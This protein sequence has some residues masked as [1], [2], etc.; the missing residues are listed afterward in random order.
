MATSQ[1]G[2]AA[3]SEQEE[4]HR[5]LLSQPQERGGA[6]DG[7][8]QRRSR[9]HLI[10]AEN[11]GQL[12]AP[13]AG[14]SSARRGAVVRAADAARD[15]AV[16]A[17]CERRT[18]NG[19]R[20]VTYVCGLYRQQNSQNPYLA[21]PELTCSCAQ[22]RRAQ[23]LELTSLLRLRAGLRLGVARL[24]LTSSMRERPRMCGA[25]SAK[26]WPQLQ[27]S[28]AHNV[29][30]ARVMLR[31]HLRLDATDGLTCCLL[32]LLGLHEGEQGGE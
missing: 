3:Q 6:D 24:L 27:S 30:Q 5:C 8:P 9:A 13:A 31:M 10:I 18:E 12:V 17:H 20:L 25:A 1:P 26:T 2:T 14:A 21:C 32:V 4:C 11:L 22:G 19:E 16:G 15:E 7:R 29:C 28:A 23:P